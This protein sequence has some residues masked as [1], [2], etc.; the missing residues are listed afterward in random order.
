VSK[1]ISVSTR[2]LI[3]S[4]GNNVGPVR[5]MTRRCLS[6]HL[7]PQCEN[8]ACRSFTR[9]HLVRDLLK[10]RGRFVS[11]ALTL[12]RAWVVAGSPMAPCRALAGYGAWSDFCRQPLLWLGMD[13]PIEGLLEVMAEDPERATLISFM[14]AWMGAFGK[15]GAMVRDAVN[16]VA[17]G[18]QREAELQDV[19]E[20][21]A[22]DR[23]SVNPRKLGWWI[24]KHVGHIAGGRRIARGS[25][26][27]SSE[28]WRVEEVPSVSSVSRVSSPGLDKVVSNG[29]A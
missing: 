25:G 13:D 11:A 4:S 16:R 29:C 10:D 22:N 17:A 12:V 20:E 3:L 14:D 28:R 5:D 8:P 21:I 2:T 26:N 7:A 6:I 9:P 27:A 18:G 24:K 15:T 19:L 23:G 1:T